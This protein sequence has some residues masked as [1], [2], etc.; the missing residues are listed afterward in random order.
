MTTKPELMDP[1]ELGQRL[2]ATERLLGTLVAILSARDPKI[3]DQ[4]QAVFANPDF[5]ADEAGVAAT[6]TW[7]RVSAELKDTRAM[8]NALGAAKS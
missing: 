4:L 8:I 7:A 5:S 6:Q 2:I 3:L 1:A